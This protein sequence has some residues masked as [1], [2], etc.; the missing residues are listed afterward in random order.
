MLKTTY[1]IVRVALAGAVIYGT[2][3]PTYRLAE[4]LEELRQLTHSARLD[5]ETRT[6]EF[7]SQIFDGI[8][9]WANGKEREGEQ[10]TIRR[11]RRSIEDTVD[12]DCNTVDDVSYEL[13]T[14]ELGKR[15]VYELRML[16]RTRELVIS[17]PKAAAE[18]RYLGE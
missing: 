10:A 3:A 7:H 13:P 4:G 12:I 15:G 1:E 8:V 14:I 17:F 5:M 11:L 18:L 2:V 16:C 6:D 9:R